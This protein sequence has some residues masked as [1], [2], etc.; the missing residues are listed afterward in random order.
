MKVLTMNKR[1]RELF[2]THTVPSFALG[3][4]PDLSKNAHGEY[5]NST[6]ED[7]WQ[8]FQ[9]AAE[10]IVKECAEEL[11]KWKSE[12]FPLDPEHAATALKAHFRV[13]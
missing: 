12:P 3:M 7:H 8:T 11:L 1:I 5:I 10:L 9:E 4:D 2:E 6:L 13:N